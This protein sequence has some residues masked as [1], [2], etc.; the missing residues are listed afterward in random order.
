MVWRAKGWSGTNERDLDSGF[1][2]RINTAIMNRDSQSD[3]HR[4]RSMER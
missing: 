2:F 3:E 4:V 1:L